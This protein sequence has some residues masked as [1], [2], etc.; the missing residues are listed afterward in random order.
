VFTIPILL[1]LVLGSGAGVTNFEAARL[2]RNLV[3]TVL[4]PLLAGAAAQAVIPGEAGNQRGASAPGHS[5]LTFG[6]CRS[7][8]CGGGQCCSLLLPAPPLAP[9]VRAGAHLWKKHHRKQLSYLSAICLCTVPWMQVSKASAARLALTPAALSSAAAAALALHIVLLAGNLLA[10]RLV[11]FSADSA[12]NL[13][14]R[15]AV[16]LCASQKTL[17]VAVAVLAQLSGV[18]GAAGGF[19]VIPC[20]LAHLI[21]TVFDSALVSRWNAREAAGLSPLD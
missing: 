21:Q 9:P 1:S 4:L 18:L 10:T 17:P 3:I 7:G 12:Q 15:K 5:L 2:F 16:V 20:V 11:R 13:A 19:A 6:A 8:A 14:I